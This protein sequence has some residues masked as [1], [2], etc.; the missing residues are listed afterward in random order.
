MGATKPA[1][2]RRAARIAD[3]LIGPA[4]WVR[5]TYVE[6]LRDAGKD[7]RHPRILSFFPWRFTSEDPKRDWD[8]LKPYA[9]YQL[10]EYA[11]WNIAAGDPSL[12]QPPKDYADLESRGIYFIGNPEEMIANIRQAFEQAPFERLW[13]M[14][15]WPGADLGMATRSMELFATE[16]MP[17]LR[18]LQ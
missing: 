6:A 15:V 4:P 2:I 16:V 14:A 5:E 18:D 10:R 8:L 1:A 7:W 17:A 11:A 13:N 3:G 12:G 9:L